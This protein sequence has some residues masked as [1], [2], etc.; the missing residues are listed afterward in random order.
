LV[1]SAYRGEASRAGWTTEADLLD[2]QRT[3]PAGVAELIAKPGSCLLLA[4]RDGVLL[5]AFLVFAWA[6]E[7]LYLYSGAT[8]AGLK[9]GANH[10][11]QWHA[12]LWAKALGCRIYDFWGIPDALGQAAACTDAAERAQLE[13][14]AQSDPLYGV[15][16]FKKGFGGQVVRYAPA[17]DQVYVPALYA[18]WRRRFR[19]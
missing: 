19:S 3:D 15:F 1:E 2:G 17:Y 13:Q 8:E 4:E 14:A 12:L 9:S 11:L 10:A 5:A 18:L 16:R 6:G 7:G